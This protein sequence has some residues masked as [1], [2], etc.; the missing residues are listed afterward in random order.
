MKLVC[1]AMLWI[2]LLCIRIFLLCI[3]LIVLHVCINPLFQ[4]IS[5]SRVCEI[6]CVLSVSDY[7]SVCS[8]ILKFS[9]LGDRDCECGWYLSR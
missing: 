8:L 7:P 3:E 6:V 9:Y 4:A 1:L 2:L 5:S